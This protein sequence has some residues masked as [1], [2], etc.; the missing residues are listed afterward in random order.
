VR[1]NPESALVACMN[2]EASLPAQDQFACARSSPAPDWSVL[3]EI[4]YI[5]W[6]AVIDSYS[7]IQAHGFSSG[8]WRPE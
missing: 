5:E 7:G 2:E 8:V 1:D 6:A 3:R 4:E